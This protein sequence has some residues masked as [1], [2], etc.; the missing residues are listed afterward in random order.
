M[1]SRIEDQDTGRILIDGMNVEIPAER[2]EQAKRAAEVVDTE[3]FEFPMV[4]GLRPMN[5]DLT[6]LV[7]N[8]TWRPAL[9][10]T[11]VGGMPPLE[12]AGNVLRPQTS[13][14]LSLRLP[15]TPMASL[16]RAAEEALLRD[17]PNGAQ[18]TWT[19]KRPPPAGTPR[20]WRRG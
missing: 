4:D 12:S 15:P 2:L 14:K 18:V 7:L 10:V 3:I 19:W 16:R 1:L 11:G 6:E 20:R 5:E 17:P 13:V 8:R 9:S